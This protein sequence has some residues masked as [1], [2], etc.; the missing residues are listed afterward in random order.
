[1]HGIH[2]WTERTENGD[3]REVRAT[4]FGGEWTIQ[5]RLRG[6]ACWD[7]HRPPFARDLRTLLDLLG[8]KYQRRR[9]SHDDI[10]Q[11]AALLKRAEAHEHPAP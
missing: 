11:V 6:N 2:A 9:A 1:M 10:K 5:S 3:K 7:Y 4:K 8:R